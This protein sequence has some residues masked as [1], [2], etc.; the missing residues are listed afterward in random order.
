MP[1]I[2]IVYGT[3]YGHTARIAEAIGSTLCAQGL[4]VDTAAA[5]VAPGPAGYDGVIVAAS[6]VAGGYQKP[7]VRWVKAHRASLCA[8]PT[9][10]VSVCLGVLQADPAVHKTLDDIVQRFRART[11][12]NPGEVRLVAGA[13]AYTRYNWILRLIMRRIARRA[14]GDTDTRR[15]FVYT[16]WADLEL[17]ARA[18]AGRISAAAA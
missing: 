2:L 14:G 5:D 8:V 11:L 16:N 6:I 12:W 18:F 3:T 4:A 9:A 15:D 1:R 17:F 13:L 7:V 10:F